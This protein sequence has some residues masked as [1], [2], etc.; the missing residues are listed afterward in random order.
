[1]QAKLE[2]EVKDAK[3]NAYGISL[4]YGAPIVAFISAYLAAKAYEKR[5]TE[6]TQEVAELRAELRT[7]KNSS[8]FHGTNSSP[9]PKS[10]VAQACFLPE[11]PRSSSQSK[12]VYVSKHGSKYH[13]KYRCSNATT[14][15]KLDD[16]P[17]T[18]EPC[19]NCVPK[20]MI[21]QISQYHSSAFSRIEYK[22]GSLILTFSG[23]STY[24]YYNVPESVY[25][26]ILAAP[27]KGKFYHEHIKD[28]YPY[29]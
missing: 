2:A 24:S 7:A 27:S 20:S 18:Y 19:Q 9:L 16:L 3:Q 28:Q 1:M 11:K 17:L 23:G 12:T 21:R 29:L 10:S 5:E 25:K 8:N 6:L 4:F 15:V 14:A 26:D 13:C 22:D